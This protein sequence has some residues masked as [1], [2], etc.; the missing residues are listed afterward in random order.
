[1]HS[2]EHMIKSMFT[3]ILDG[4]EHMHAKGVYRRDI[5]LENV[6]FKSSSVQD[7]PACKITD[8]GL[9]TREHYS[10]DG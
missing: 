2:E 7:E 1:M 5:E 3:H 6:L 10:I 9:S 4:I 8:F